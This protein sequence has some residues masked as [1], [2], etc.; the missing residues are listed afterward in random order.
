M[1]EEDKKLSKYASLENIVKN[2]FY[3]VNKDEIE[4]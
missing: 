3:E 1:S 2:S 4:C